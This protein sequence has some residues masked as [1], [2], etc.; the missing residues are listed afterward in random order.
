M[1]STLNTRKHYW[2]HWISFIPPGVDPHLQ[3]VD[4]PTGLLFIQIFAQCVQQGLYGC[5]KQIK[6]SGVQAAIG[7]IT[8]TIELA[9]F[10]NP[11]HWPRTTNCHAS[12]TLQTESYQCADPTVVRQDAVPVN[13]PNKIFESSRNCHDHRTKAVG[14]LAVIAFYFLLHVGEYTFHNQQKCRTQQFRLQDIKFLARGKEVLANHLKCME[15]EVDTVSLVIDNQKNGVR[16]DIL[17]HHAIMRSNPCCPVRAVA[18]RVIDM[19]DDGADPQ[20][21]ICSFQEASSLPWQHV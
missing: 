16:G 6:M 18:S 12:L 21:L 8:K 2:A 11:L 3:N 20:T 9:G 19:V 4:A 7:A 15:H 13:V 17:S 14:E 5:G 10:T 1:A